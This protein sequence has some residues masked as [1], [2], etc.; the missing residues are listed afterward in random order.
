MLPPASLQNL[1]H[2]GLCS[3]KGGTVVGGGGSP[4]VHCSG[5]YVVPGSIAT[6]NY[7]PSPTTATNLG[8][9]DTSQ[10]ISASHVTNDKKVRKEPD[11]CFH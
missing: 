1:S 6:V 10:I 5:H 4:V 2:F 3:V 7:E 11:F 8:V 9:W